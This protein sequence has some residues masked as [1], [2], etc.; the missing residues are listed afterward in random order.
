LVER[1]SGFAVMAKVDR[2]TS[3][4]V[5]AAVIE[6]LLPVVDRVKTVT[7]VMARSL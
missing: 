2:K 1:K 6:H 3:E 4:Q 7:F 5:S